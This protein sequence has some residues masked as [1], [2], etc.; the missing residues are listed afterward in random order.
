M[1][2]KYEA[3]TKAYDTM[4]RFANES[5]CKMLEAETTED[6][7]IHDAQQEAFMKAAAAI[8]DQIMEVLNQL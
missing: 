6:L 7:I 5:F 8:H 4:I 2:N 1:F 3:L